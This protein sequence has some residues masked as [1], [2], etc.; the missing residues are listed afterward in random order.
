[1]APKIELTYFNHEGRGEKVRIA[2]D[3]AGLEF[4][5]KRIEFQEFPKLKPSLPFGTIPIMT[6]DGKTIAQSGAML[7][8]IGRQGDG[9]LY[10]SD[11]DTMIKV[12]EVLNIALDFENESLINFY[13]G[14][15]APAYGLKEVDKKERLKL[16]AAAKDF[17]KKTTVPQYLVCFAKFLQQSGG[18]FLAGDKPTVA[19]CFVLPQLRLL[20]DVAI[21]H[22]PIVAEWID[23]M[24][25]LP[26][27]KARYGGS[28][29]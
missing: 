5:D 2:L 8:W 16:V 25:A 19:D 1:M 29:L 23:R 28:K 18:K 20:K 7:R 21:K 3:L 22:Q 26:A 14:I 17:L 4:T 12:E 24:L 9:S 15:K 11:L 27:L 6:V 13:M 10:P